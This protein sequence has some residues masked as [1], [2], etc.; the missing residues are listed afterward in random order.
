MSILLTRIGVFLVLLTQFLEQRFR[1]ERFRVVDGNFWRE[2]S[3]EVEEGESDG[4][5]REGRL[6]GEGGRGG[7]SGEEG[8]GSCGRVRDDRFEGAT[9]GEG[10]KN[11]VVEAAAPEARSVSALRNELGKD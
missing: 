11:R 2:T 3:E 6:V 9:D 1:V 7:G 4:D 8:R 10:L 5:G